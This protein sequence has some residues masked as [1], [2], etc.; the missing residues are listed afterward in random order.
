MAQKEALWASLGFSAGEGKVYEAIMNSDNATL[1]LIHEHTGI[2]RRNVYDIINKLIS[3][4]L[5][6]YFEENGRKVYRLTSP[7]NILT[8]LEEEEK[9]INSK[10]ELLSAELP[11][12]MKLYEAAKPEFD[13]RIYRGREAV[14]AVF[15][16]GLEYADVHFIGGNWGMVK[17]LGKEWVDRWMEKRIARKVRMHDIVTSPEKFLTD[18]PA[19][20]DPY[21]E[22]RVLP[23]EFGS[24]NVILIFGNRVVNLFWGENTF[25]FEIENPDIAKSYLAY[26]NYLWKTLD[27]VVKV[28]YGAEGM[29]AVHEKTYSRL[30]RGEDYFY[31]GGPSSQS[32]SLHA[33]WRRDH[34]RRVKTGIKCRILFHPSMDRKEVANRNTYEGCDA[35]YMP[36]EINSPVWLLGYKDVIAMQVVAKNP[37]TIEITNQ[38]IADSFRA[39]FEEFWR[40]SRPLK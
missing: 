13:V 28:Y 38:Q 37:V 8:Y 17:Y 9:G 5:V 23:P 4:G 30:S 20:S 7:K 3:K 14:R 16:E 1:Q 18:Y 21:Y 10:K 32:E 11:S 26:F 25:A 2:E 29:R 33:Y 15:N 24:P 36:V 22:F 12:L 27:S 40:K 34:A 39:Y 31:L 6:S 19:P 35:R